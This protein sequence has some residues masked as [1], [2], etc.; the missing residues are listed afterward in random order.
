MDLAIFGYEKNRRDD[1]E[2]NI[3]V[4]LER[5]ASIKLTVL[6]ATLNDL[7][8]Q[9]P[10]T[11]HA[12]IPPGQNSLYIK[13]VFAETRLYLNGALAYEFSKPGSYPAFMNDPPTGGAIIPLPKSAE[14]ISLRLEYISPAQR[15]ELSLPALYTGGAGAIVAMLFRSNGFSLF[16]SL[17]LIFIGVAISAVSLVF[18]RKITDGTPFLWLGIFSLSAERDRRKRH[19]GQKYPPATSRRCGGAAALCHV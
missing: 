3:R 17:I 11:L 19:V 16:F 9:T 6:P 13:S 15:N 7:L 1:L 8:P 10:V 5:D 18:L 4:C 2:A 14:E 12:R